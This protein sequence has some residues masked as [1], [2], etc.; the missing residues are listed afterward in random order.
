MR[1]EENRL[2]AI[3]TRMV[4]MLQFIEPL[5]F[6]RLADTSRSVTRRPRLLN[7][8]AAVRAVTKAWADG[9]GAYP[10]LHHGNSRPGI[11][12]A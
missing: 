11:A 10:G 3:S 12:A 5:H 7:C 4:K 8:C 2:L 1:A 9:L 6:S